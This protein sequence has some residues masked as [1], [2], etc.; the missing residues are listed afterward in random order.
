MKNLNHFS[1]NRA[2]MT[3]MLIMMLIGF[4]HDGWS[5]RSWGLEVRPGV[6]FPTSDLTTNTSLKTGFGVEGTVSYNFMTNLGVYGGWSWNRFSSDQSFAGPSM[7]FEETG[8]TYGLQYF[9]PI[10]SSDSRLFFKGGGLWNH[11][12]VENSNGELIDDTGHGFGWQLEAGI[13]LPLSDR[14][15]IQPGIRYRSL[16]R[17]FSAGNTSFEANLNYLSLGVGIVRS[18]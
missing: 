5:Q 10:G 1:A 6:N 7:D 13:S 12:E 15:N 18:F 14:W 16:S 4:S 2:W 3:G 8:Y 9:M 17:D 11:I